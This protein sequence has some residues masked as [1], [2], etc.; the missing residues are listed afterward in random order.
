MD[1]TYIRPLP[2]K[3]ALRHIRL[4][5]IGCFLALVGYVVFP[6]VVL[7]RW[8]IPLLIQAYLAGAT[9]VLMNCLRTLASHRW[10]SDGEEGT[11]VDQL[12]DSVTLDSDSLAAAI[13]NPVGLRYHATHHSVPVAAVSQYP[14]RT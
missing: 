6:L 7:H 3:A 2:T 4:Q 9:L 14:G 11:F 13:I 12:L 5:E 10:S 8:P 1:P